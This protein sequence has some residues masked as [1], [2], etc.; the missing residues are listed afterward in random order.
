[1]VFLWFFFLIFSNFFSSFF[2]DK[3]NFFLIPIDLFGYFKCSRSLFFIFLKVHIFLVEKVD[4][5]L[6]LTTFSGTPC[7]VPGFVGVD[8]ISCCDFPRS[9]SRSGTLS[10]S[11]LARPSAASLFSDAVSCS[12]SRSACRSSR[13]P[14][15]AMATSRCA[16]PVSLLLAT[17]IFNFS[18]WVRSICGLAEEVVP[19]GR[20]ASCSGSRPAGVVGWAVRSLNYTGKKMAKISTSAGSV[21]ALLTPVHGKN[22]TELARRFPVIGQT[23]YP[24]TNKTKFQKKKILKN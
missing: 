1:M 19:A 15:R 3:Y 7:L 21:P 16:S 4:D 22:K 18:T 8:S 9:H 5:F 20:R 12:F 13:R 2:N 11:G 14:S 17:V 6:F 10:D 23:T 24:V